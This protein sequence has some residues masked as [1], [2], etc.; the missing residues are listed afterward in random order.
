M[1]CHGGGREGRPAGKPVL[2][3]ADIFRVHG[4]EHLRGHALSAEQ[5][6]VMEHILACRTAVLGGHLD[7]C[8]QC[9]HEEQG[10]NSCGDR[11]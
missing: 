7:K 1:Q 5:Q 8:D 3:V 9:G 11:H 2:E 4:Q 6:K 10:Y